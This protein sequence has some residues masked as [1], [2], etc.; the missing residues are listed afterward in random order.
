MARKHAEQCD[1]LPDLQEQ[2][3]G[4]VLEQSQSD[5]GFILDADDFTIALMTMRLTDCEVKQAKPATKRLALRL[6]SPPV[7]LQKTRKDVVEPQN[8]FFEGEDCYTGCWATEWR[9][10][11]LAKTTPSWPKCA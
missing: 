5:L 3:A 7:V 4:F 9:R 8:T 1:F 6:T 10:R 11:Q 2:D